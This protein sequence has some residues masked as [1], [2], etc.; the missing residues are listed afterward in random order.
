MFFFRQLITYYWNA[1]VKY[2]VSNLMVTI[3]SITLSV[4]NEEIN[5][6]YCCSIPSVGDVIPYCSLP[7]TLEL[8]ARHT[9]T[10][11]LSKLGETTVCTCFFTRKGG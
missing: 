7:G 1:N 4:N 11:N 2:G 10:R 5:H 9:N 8:E 3:V 6:L